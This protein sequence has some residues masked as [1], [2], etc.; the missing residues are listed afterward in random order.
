MTD[1]NERWSFGGGGTLVFQ[2]QVDEGIREL[3]DGR[4]VQEVYNANLGGKVTLVL[5]PETLH[6]GETISPALTPYP[7]ELTQVVSSVAG[8]RV[9]WA[10]DGGQGPDPNVRYMLRWETLDSN[11]DQPRDPIPPPTPLKLYAFEP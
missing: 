8:M 7:S 5:D 9:R 2:I 1:W 6:A 10:G 3:P 11:Q 4:L